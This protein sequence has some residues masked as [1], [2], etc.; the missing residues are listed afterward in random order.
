MYLKSRS[1]EILS[2][3]LSIVCQI[4]WGKGFNNNNNNNNNSTFFPAAGGQ[5]LVRPSFSVCTLRDAEK[6]T[7]KHKVLWEKYRCVEKI[8]FEINVRGHC[9][10]NWLGGGVQQQQPQQP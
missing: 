10:S 1:P 5:I 8:G 7:H 3:D 9:M 4:G 6:K 2:T